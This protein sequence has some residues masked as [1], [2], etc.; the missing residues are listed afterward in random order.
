MDVLK[1]TEQKMKDAIDHLKNELKNIRTGRANSAILDGVMIEV[2]GTQMRLPDIANVTVPESRQLLITPYDANNTAVIGNTLMKGNLNLQPVVDG[3]VV[4]I[5]IPPMDETVRKDM[6]KIVKKKSEESRVS[7]RN[8]RRDSNELVRK[9][10]S[11]SEISEDIMKKLEKGIQ[12]LT[13]TYCK[14]ADE[15]SEKKEKEVMEV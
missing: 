14:N 1:E 5:N 8:T 3:N 15:L 11:D 7:I 2:Y 4:R 10:K 13:D 6:T 12:N 9:Q